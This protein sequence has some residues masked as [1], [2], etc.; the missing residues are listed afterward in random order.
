MADQQEGVLAIARG[1]VIGVAVDVLP[2]DR[3]VLET[4]QDMAADFGQLVRVVGADV[5][6][7]GLGL[8][9]ER[10]QSHRKDGQLAGTA[11]GLVQPP[12]IGVEARR[13]LGV[14]RADMGGVFPVRAPAFDRL[15]G[16]QFAPFDP[17]EDLL[18][19]VAKRDA[20]IVDQRDRPVG[21]D[22]GIQA[23]FGIGR[24]AADQ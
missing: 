23:E 24:A 14:D 16:V 8:G 6:D 2:G 10:V 1:D 21:A 4:R 18:G 12:G 11:R 20:Q 15:R 19:V 17:G 7:R 9:H 5:E 13:G 3:Q 22:L